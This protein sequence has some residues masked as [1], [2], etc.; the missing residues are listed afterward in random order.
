MLCTSS[1]NAQP[2]KEDSVA[3]KSIF[4]KSLDDQK[5]WENLRYLSKNIGARINGSPQLQRAI[6]WA[7]AELSH[8]QLEKVYLQPV[9]VPHWERGGKEYAAIHVKDSTLS[10][11]VCALGGSVATNG[12]LKAKVVEIKSWEELKALSKK[13]V[14]GKYVFFNRAMDPTDAESFNAYLKAVDQRAIGA[15]E[16]A[17]KGAIGALIRSL[18]LSIHDYPHTG[19]MQ[20]NDK[21]NKI[22]SAALSTNSADL[23]S[24][25]LKS[26]PD[27]EI[28]LKM[29]CATFPDTVSYNV[30]GEISGSQYSDEIIT[31]GA[32]IDSWDLSE[33]ASDNGSGVVQAIEAIRILSHMK[34]KPLRTIRAVIYTDEEQSATGGLTYAEEAKRLKERHIACIESDAG[35]FVPV[36]FRMSGDSAALA[37]LKDMMGLF[38]PYNCSGIEHDPRGVDIAPMREQAKAIISLDCSDHRFFNIH[39]SALDTMD[40]LNKREINLGTGAMTSLVYLISKYGL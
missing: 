26:S 1:A 2:T 29:T 19:A 13:E 4:S 12:Y 28:G 34:T 32:H 5:G 10:L 14:S 6:E 9:M 33:S 22:P 16:A 17:K 40:K 24:S 37:S 21:V 18:T 23:L 35:G 20:Y 3:V 27:L 11:S 8:M 38:A 36:G 7:K 30:I 25:L 39:H 31:V 15:I